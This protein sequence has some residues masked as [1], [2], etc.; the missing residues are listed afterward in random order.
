[1]KFKVMG[2]P[3]WTRSLHHLTNLTGSIL[4]VMSNKIN[5]EGILLFEQPFARVRSHY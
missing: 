3:R 1:M 2:G 5:S 4:Y